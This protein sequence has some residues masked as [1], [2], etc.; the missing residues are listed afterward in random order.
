MMWS[1]TTRMSQGGSDSN[2]VLYHSKGGVV[3]VL[4]LRLEAGHRVV[5]S[6]ALAKEDNEHLRE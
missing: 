5:T 6:V 3:E 2:Y 1:I 4:Q